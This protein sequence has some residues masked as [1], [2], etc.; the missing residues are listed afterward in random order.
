VPASI[1]IPKQ[2][3]PSFGGGHTVVI[4][5]LLFAPEKTRTKAK[6]KLAK[7]HFTFMFFIFLVDEKLSFYF[8]FLNIGNMKA[9]KKV[10]KRVP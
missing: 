3:F 5:F 2:N 7:H 10:W 6:I 4:R 9:W 1:T 8:L